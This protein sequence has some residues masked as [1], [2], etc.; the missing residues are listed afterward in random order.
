MYKH[1][2]KQVKK[3]KNNLNQ[4]KRSNKPHVHRPEI[5]EHPFANKCKDCGEIY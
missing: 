1:T 2:R 4:N 5:T 3:L